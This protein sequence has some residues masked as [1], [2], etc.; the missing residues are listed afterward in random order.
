MATAAIFLSLGK[1]IEATPFL[2]FLGLAPIFALFYNRKKESTATLSLYVKIL[3]VLLIA[4]LLW[5]TA[6]PNSTT[7]WI[8]PILYALAMLLSFAVYGFTDKYV[9]NRLGFFTVPIY[10]LALEYLLLQV[11]PG[12]A[13]FFLGSAFSEHPDLISWNVYTGFLGVSL[14]ILIVNIMLFYFLFKDD[15]LFNGTIRWVGLAATIIAACIPFF[16]TTDAVA[17]THED[18]MNSVTAEKQI[19]GSSEFI[20]KTAVWISMLLLMYSFVKKEVSANERP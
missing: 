10:W 18:L 17:I 20:G 14:W 12:F 11:Y 3:L 8:L 7:S 15:A 2:I 1:V 13:R 6:Y 16:L 19:Y 9:R 5:N 4:F